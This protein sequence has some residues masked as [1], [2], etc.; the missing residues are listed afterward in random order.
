MD[1]ETADQIV[2]LMK[3]IETLKN[4]D[5]PVINVS[6]EQAKCL[7]SLVVSYMTAAAMDHKMTSSLIIGELDK[8]WDNFIKEE[9]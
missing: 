2:K 5:V 3:D 1:K 7:E 6:K 8:I 9:V 4:G